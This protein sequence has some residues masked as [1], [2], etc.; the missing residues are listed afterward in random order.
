MR[1]KHIFPLVSALVL[2]ACSSQEAPLTEEQMTSAVPAVENSVKPQAPK[3]DNA[4]ASG[5][6]VN[7]NALATPAAPGAPATPPAPRVPG[8]R[9]SSVSV[10]T[11]TVA[12]T[13][14]DG[15]HGTLTPRILN[16]LAKYNAKC[17][18]FV[19]GSNVQR[20]PGIVSRMASEGHEVA[21]HSWNHPNLAQSSYDTVSSQMSRTNEAIMNACGRKPRLMRPPYGACS[22]A[23]SSRL[24][25]DFG[26]TTVLWSVDTNDWRKPGV[27]AI[28]SRAV[29]GARPGSIILVHD[30]HSSTADAVE[31]IVRGLKERGFELVTVSTLMNRGYQ[32]ANGKSSDGPGIS[33]PAPVSVPVPV[34]APAAAPEMPTPG[35]LPIQAVDDVADGMASAI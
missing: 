8:V 12:L 27:S 2:A 1:F 20:N 31:G 35:D 24:K 18:F 15:P 16:I 30:I 14:D 21:N 6:K 19:L 11:K 25:S 17:T 26:L 23:L 13:F 28:V 3:K 33:S 9:V 29:N 34:P 4:T 22:S 32:Y 7:G 5:A 10:P